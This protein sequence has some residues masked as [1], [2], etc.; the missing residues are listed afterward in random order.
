MEIDLEFHW[1][2]YG[3]RVDV[4]VQA[5]IENRDLSRTTYAE[6]VKSTLLIQNNTKLDSE[7]SVG[8]QNISVEPSDSKYTGRKYR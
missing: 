5:E 4:G 8:A 6:V 3:L 2:R 7:R 1:K